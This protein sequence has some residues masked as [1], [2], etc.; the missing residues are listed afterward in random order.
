M[1]THKRAK[2][3]RRSSLPVTLRLQPQSPVLEKHATLTGCR[4]APQKPVV[5]SQY[6]IGE[7]TPHTLNP[8]SQTPQLESGPEHQLGT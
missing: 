2:C 6:G 8:L 3:C 4:L 7:L 1:P 5:P